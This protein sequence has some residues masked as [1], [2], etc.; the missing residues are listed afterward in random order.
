MA[1]T[2]RLMAQSMEIEESLDL[3]PLDR[4]TGMVF[5]FCILVYFSCFCCLLLTFFKI[6]FF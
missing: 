5:T 6:N 1:Q 4:C 2:S 3:A